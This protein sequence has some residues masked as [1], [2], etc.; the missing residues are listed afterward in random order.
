MVFVI[1]SIRKEKNGHMPPG[2]K[3]TPFN[4]FSPV[5]YPF[6][7]SRIPYQDVKICLETFFCNYLP[8]VGDLLHRLTSS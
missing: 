1:R 5:A 7:R 8:D 4:C 2:M 6:T 3:W